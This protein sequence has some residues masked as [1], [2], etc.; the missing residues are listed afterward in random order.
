MVWARKA[1]GIAALFQSFSNEK[2]QYSAK[3]DVKGF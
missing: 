2:Q 1:A 3:I